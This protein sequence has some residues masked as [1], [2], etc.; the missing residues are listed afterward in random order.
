M[1]E[2]AGPAA[3]GR[4]TTTLEVVRFEITAARRYGPLKK[5]MPS[6]CGREAY[7]SMLLL[8]PLVPF[9]LSAGFRVIVA[10][11]PAAANRALGT[12]PMSPWSKFTGALLIWLRPAWSRG[13]LQATNH[14]M[15][16]MW[17][18]SPRRLKRETLVA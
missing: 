18:E 13:V 3:K 2:S 15:P 17:M 12:E 10:E 1:E 9:Q 11:V 16:L 4:V 14:A 6:F 8:L 7:S 5:L